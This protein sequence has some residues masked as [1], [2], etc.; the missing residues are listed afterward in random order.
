MPVCSQV[1]LKNFHN[2]QII[3]EPPFEP[4][5]DPRSGAGASLPRYVPAA[6][7]YHEPR[8]QLTI[9]ALAINLSRPFQLQ[10]NATFVPASQ[11]TAPGTPTYKIFLLRLS[12]AETVRVPEQI[13][14]FPPTTRDADGA[15]LL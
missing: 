2:P 1:I 7:Q 5:T 11:N 4:E 6:R 3:D 14:I 9:E 15:H 8:L 10:D 13:P 12:L